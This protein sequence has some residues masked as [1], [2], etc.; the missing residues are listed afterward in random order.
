MHDVL[1]KVNMHIL[2]LP[3]DALKLI[4]KDAGNTLNLALVHSVFHQCISE[5]QPISLNPKLNYYSI[6]FLQWLYS[7][8]G[9][10]LDED[11]ILEMSFKQND[12]VLLKWCLRKFNLPM[13][14]RMIVGPLIY[15]HTDMKFLQYYLDN[16]IKRVGKGDTA[17]FV[18]IHSGY[19]VQP[20]A[21]T[22]TSYAASSSNAVK[23]LLNQGFPWC[24]KT[25]SAAAKHGNLDLIKWAI[26][27]GYEWCPKTTSKAAKYGH[28]DL[29][30]WCV[31]HGCPMAP[32][33]IAKAACHNHKDIMEWAIMNGANW[34]ED[35]IYKAAI[36]GHHD[37]FE[38]CLDE[39]WP[40]FIQKNAYFNGTTEDMTRMC[41]GLSDV[42][43]YAAEGGHLD[44]V[45]CCVKRNIPIHKQILGCSIEYRPILEFLLSNFRD[46]KWHVNTLKEIAHIDK[47]TLQ[48]ALDH[49]CP[50]CY[51]TIYYLVVDSYGASKAIKKHNY[52]MIEW[53]LQHNFPWR[54]KRRVNSNY[55]YEENHI[56]YY[57]LEDITCANNIKWFYEKAGPSFRWGSFTIGTILYRFQFENMYFLVSLDTFDVERDSSV[58]I[59]NT[60]TESTSNV[61]FDLVKWCI[62]RGCRWGEASI[63]DFLE[64]FTIQQLEWCRS[65]RC[66]FTR[67]TIKRIETMKR[68]DVSLLKWA[69]KII[70]Y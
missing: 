62:E 17:K 9:K 60:I 35:V 63:D 28:L 26:K 29:L 16:V 67:H 61:L 56:L 37:L 34:S 12:L 11:D 54:S 15:N 66:R 53:C 59:A 40:M 21:A 36:Y 47:E 7:I 52:D 70:T 18:N 51:D 13:E 48:W 57:I 42:S 68:I 25:T 6:E 10:A 30:K 19:S 24:P 65:H 22:M 2:E 4:L 46:L 23:W 43:L 20:Q 49:G 38:W 5:P 50:P 14:G 1:R 45:K 44:I 27:Q 3:T 39:A 64:L 69:M 8:Y 58:T 31:N 41:P 33:T 32:N 55:G